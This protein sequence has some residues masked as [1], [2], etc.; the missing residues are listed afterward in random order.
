MRAIIAAALPLTLAACAADHS[1]PVDPPPADRVEVEQKAA[2]RLGT[3]KKVDDG[4]FQIP[5]ERS[6]ELV[7]TKGVNYP[8]KLTSPKEAANAPAPAA[9]KPAGDAPAKFAVDA[10]KAKAGEALFKSKTCSACHSLDGSKLVGPSMK[11]FW[12]RAVTLADG[13]AIWAD[14]AYF[15]ESIKNPTAK[16]SGGYPPAM[17][18]LPV[19]DA[20]IEQLLH[21][22][23]SL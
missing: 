20:E 22:V 13:K 19:N 7:A 9:G 15:T 2:E 5:V 4:K 10:A 17:P 11:G 21:Y 14:Q 8:A 16:I 6:M 1:I 18:V 3:Y 12:G 23:A